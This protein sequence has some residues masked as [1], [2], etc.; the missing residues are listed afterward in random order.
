MKLYF[1]IKELNPKNYTLTPEVE[2]NLNELIQKMS[3]FREAYGKSLKVTSGL[4]SNE[5]QA[6]INPKAPK[7]NHLVG[8][9]VDISDADGSIN[10]FCKANV[11][12]LESIGLWC[13]ERQGPWQHFQTVPPKSGKRFFN[14]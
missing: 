9:A 1:S 11:P 2:A 10:A 14:P 12:L 7:S 13:E 4:R 8:R 6:R 3:A 5:D